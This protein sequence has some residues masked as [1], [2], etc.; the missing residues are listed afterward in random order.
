V[1][2]WQGHPGHAEAKQQECYGLAKTLKFKTDECRTFFEKLTTDP[3][4]M[5]TLVLAV[6]TLLLWWATLSVSRS[7]KR[8][9]IATH[10]PKLRVRFIDHQGFDQ[11]LHWSAFLV[12]ANVG[13]TECN[14]PWTRSRHC[15]PLYSGQAVV[16]ARYQRFKYGS[17]T[18]SRSDL[19]L[20]RAE[21]LS[22]QLAR[23]DYLFQ[24]G[25]DQSKRNL[26][27]R[28]NSLPRRQWECAPY[29]ILP[30]I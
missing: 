10:R 2:L 20:W 8:E 1:F 18:A 28:R 22:H 9:F 26:R 19:A 4:A 14:H 16:A 17:P 6:S 24:Y 15:A 13:D 30:A 21:S 7:A 29:R 5:F 23:P 11:N 25:R 3:V 12:I 27:I